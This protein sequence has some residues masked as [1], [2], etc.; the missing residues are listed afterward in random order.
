MSIGKSVEE[1]RPRLAA[2]EWG[3]MAVLAA[4]TLLVP[5]VLSSGMDPFRLPKEL[6]FRAEAIVLLTLAV[7]W[8]TSQRRTWTFARRPE[9]LTTAA[10]VCWSLILMARCCSRSSP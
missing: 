3:V 9:F 7:F 5:S 1:R 8:A 4:G 6:G 10:I 2:A